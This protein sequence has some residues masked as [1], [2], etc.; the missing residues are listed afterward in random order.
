[1]EMKQEQVLALAKE[2]PALVAAHD[3]AGWLALFGQ[4]AVIEDPVGS[5]PH[6][7]SGAASLRGLPGDDPLDRFYETFIA[8]NDVH[9]ESSLDVVAGSM[10][11]RDVVISTR[12]STGITVVVPTY[13]LYET[14]EEGGA[15]R[16]KRLAA[17][18]EL[19]RMSWQVLSTGPRGL[20]TMT[21]VSY[22]MLRVQGLMGMLGYSRG[23]VQGIGAHGRDAVQR[24]ASA[25]R[26]RD[27]QTLA[28][29]FERDAVVEWPAEKA[30][31]TME[32]LS[33]VPAGMEFGIERPISSGWVTAFRFAVGTSNGHRRPGIGFFRFNPTTKRIEHAR[34]FEADAA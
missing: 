20:F 1:M 2:S 28:E 7:R 9:M 31:P 5:A 3:K 21:A 24:F 33:R 23:M 27:V 34:F 10:A 29:L 11:A 16:L 8:P 18:W 32:I 26:A 30:I 4:S 15:L 22:R 17:H 14:T 13:L 19:P 12:M 25:V 6:R